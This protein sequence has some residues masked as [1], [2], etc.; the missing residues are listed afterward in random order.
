MANFV[1]KQNVTAAM[2]GLPLNHLAPLIATSPLAY[3]VLRYQVVLFEGL[4]AFGLFNRKLRNFFLALAVVFHA[5]GGLWL[6]ITFTPV[7]IV[8]AFVDWQELWERLRPKRLVLVGAL[9]SP[10]LIW[11]AVSVALLVGALWNAG[12]GVR[13]AVNLGGLLDWRTI[14]YPVLPA[15]FVWWLMALVE[16]GR[17]VVSLARRGPRSRA[18]T[19]DLVPGASA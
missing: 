8:Y 9:S 19:P 17:S 5:V 11:S 18:G 1:L 4:F 7:L 2:E 14:W 10:L 15:A 6:G 3:T 16:L 13:G 12:G